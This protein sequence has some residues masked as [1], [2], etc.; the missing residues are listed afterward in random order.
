MTIP[1]T[2]VLQIIYPVDCNVG[3]YLIDLFLGVVSEIAGWMHGARSRK[4]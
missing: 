3:F 2:L 4:A 1:H